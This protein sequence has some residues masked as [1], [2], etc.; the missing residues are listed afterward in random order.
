MKE[1]YK[2]LLDGPALCMTCRG[3]RAFVLLTPTC[4][5]HMTVLLQILQGTQLFLNPQFVLVR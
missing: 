1:A 5:K 4:D 2:E 3:R